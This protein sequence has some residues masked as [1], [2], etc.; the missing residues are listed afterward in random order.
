MVITLQL[1]SMKSFRY[2][3]LKVSNKNGRILNVHVQYMK[4]YMCTC[5]H[6][7]MM[8]SISWELTNLVRSQIHYRKDLMLKIHVHVHALVDP[9]FLI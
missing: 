7:N 6:V 9:Y 2:H 3:N 1:E 5:V 8:K 4:A